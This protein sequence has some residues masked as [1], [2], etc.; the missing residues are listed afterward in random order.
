M[1]TN[2]G[3][4]QQLTTVLSNSSLANHLFILYSQDFTDN[5]LF[6]IAVHAYGKMPIPVKEPSIFFI[7]EAP[8]THDQFS[9]SFEPGPTNNAL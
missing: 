8:K 4:N 5:C 3:L 9:C 2:G 1:G 6:H 7:Y